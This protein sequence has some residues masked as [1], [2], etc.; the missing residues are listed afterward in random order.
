MNTKMDSL[1]DVNKI[2][3]TMLMFGASTVAPLAPVAPTPPAVVQTIAS[4]V[5]LS[6]RSPRRHSRH[7]EDR[8]REAREEDGEHA[9][10]RQC[11]STSPG[12][13]QPIS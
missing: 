6:S 10:L 7:Q 9:G 5:I 4:A 8:P 3:G 2:L 13:S 1:A 12:T 11:G